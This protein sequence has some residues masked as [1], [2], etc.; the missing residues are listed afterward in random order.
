M[1]KS[2]HTQSGIVRDR[3]NIASVRALSNSRS[4]SRNGTATAIYTEW[5]VQHSAQTQ[6]APMPFEEWVE[7]FSI[8]LDD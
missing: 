5:A 7:Q 2:T 3:H 4:R 1:R 6:E 8:Y